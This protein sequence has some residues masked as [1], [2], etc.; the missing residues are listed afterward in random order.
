MILQQMHNSLQNSHIFDTKDS[1]IKSRVCVRS[2]F[3][4][5]LGL[6]PQCIVYLHRFGCVTIDVIQYIQCDAG[7]VLYVK[8]VLRRYGA[9]CLTH[10]RL[11]KHR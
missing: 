9:G 3:V 10:Y 11:P 4:S 5:T 8:E 6:N 2:Q 7:V 1:S